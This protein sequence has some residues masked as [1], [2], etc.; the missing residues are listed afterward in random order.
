MHNHKDLDVW[1]LAIEFAMA[2]YQITKGFP[3]HE[4]YGLVSQLRRASVS[5]ASNIAEGAARQS[6]NEFI[7]FLFCSLGSASE[8]GTQLE[9]VK[10]LGYMQESAI[11]PLL[12]KRERI[13]QMLSGLI[14]KIKSR[15]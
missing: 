7:H 13:S 2:I 9:I 14:R 4:Q 3:K 11:A 1:K 12:E 6:R 5:I 15:H 10:G 8:V